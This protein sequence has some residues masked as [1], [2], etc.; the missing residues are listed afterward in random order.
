MSL[1]AITSTIRQMTTYD[2]ILA[3]ILAKPGSPNFKEEALAFGLRRVAGYHRR[4]EQKL[5][6]PRSDGGQEHTNSLEASLGM[7]NAFHVLEYTGSY[8]AMYVP[9]G[10]KGIVTASLQERNGNDILEEVRPFAVAVWEEAE[11]YNYR[12]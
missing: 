7:M 6:T 9:E 11:R 8:Q 10:M 3:T 12:Y 4:L 5:F 2:L 1:P